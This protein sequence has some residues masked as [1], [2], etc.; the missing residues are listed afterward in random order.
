MWG[1]PVGLIPVNADGFHNGPSIRK[2]HLVIIQVSIINDY[3]FGL[4]MPQR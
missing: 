1:L 3:Y 2:K 4:V